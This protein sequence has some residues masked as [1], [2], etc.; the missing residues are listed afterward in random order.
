M[1]HDIVRIEKGVALGGAV[2]TRLRIAVL[3]VLAL[4]LV[5]IWV[6]EI[7]N[8]EA[9]HDE[10]ETIQLALNLVRHG[11]QSLEQVAPY[12]PSMTREPLP[13]VTTAAAILLV[14]AFMGQAP[15]AAYF[16]GTRAA[17]LRGQNVIWM[18]VIVVAAFWI[19]WSVS[20]SFGLATGAAVLCGLLPVISG[21]VMRLD[22]LDTEAPSG[23]L[24]LIASWLLIRGVVRERIALVAASGL[25]FG[26]LALTK[27]ALLYVF[28]VM[29]ATLLLFRL[30][31][32]VRQL[33]RQP[34]KQLG[35][36]TL[37]FALVIT[38]WMARNYSHF[39]TFNIATRGGI[40][41]LLRATKNMMTPREYV[42]SFYVWAPKPLRS[43]IGL[44]LGY[45][46]KDM[47]RG[48]ALQRL[49]RTDSD[50]SEDDKRANREGR[51]EDAISYYRKAQAEQVKVALELRA[52]GHPTPETEADEIVQQRAIQRI[53]E[54]PW[55]HLALT[56]PFLWRGATFAFPLLV[57]TIVVGLRKHRSELALFAYPAFGLVM[58]Y[59]LLTH[60][61]ARYGSPTLPVAI[62]GACL[63]Y[64][65]WR[66]RPRDLNPATS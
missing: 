22:Q 25:V 44:I 12:R 51:P 26:L 57:F 19:V 43:P 59:A 14:D 52:A 54:H 5:G 15:D 20:A 66:G 48:G 18:A 16:S 2:S 24:L 36:L 30:L 37:V 38:P 34:L 61:I 9:E 40:V 6:N 62:V 39:G 64:W 33:I 47:Q 10:E 1:A 55:R 49:N 60:F 31:P 27:A 8:K 4:A 11:V 3:F 29:V 21:I 45:R 56:I 65:A 23:A 32:Q 58:F 35:V 50:F 13:V 53:K 7:E 41:L 28:V 63:A 17:W 46:K 42:G